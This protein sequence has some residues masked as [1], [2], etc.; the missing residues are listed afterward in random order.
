MAQVLTGFKKA[1]HCFDYGKLHQRPRLF[2]KTERSLNDVRFTEK[3]QLLRK[4]PK[5]IV[6]V[7]SGFTKVHTQLL[8]NNYIH[9]CNRLLLTPPTVDVSNP[10]I[11]MYRHFYDRDITDDMCSTYGLQK[12]TV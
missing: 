10:N 5:V 12:Y 11:C 2:I 3:I 1:P 4:L 7:I 8:K 9:I 6:S